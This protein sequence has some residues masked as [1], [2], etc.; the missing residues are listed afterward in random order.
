MRIVVFFMLIQLA[1]CATGPRDWLFHRKHAPTPEE[2]LAKA[3]TLRAAG[4]WEAALAVLRRGVKR[5]PERSELL[6]RL[7]ALDREW[8]AKR[9]LL[10]DR[11]LATQLASMLTRRKLLGQLE[12]AEQ[13]DLINQ[14]RLALL[15]SGLHQSRGALLDCARRQATRDVR[16]ARQ[17][18]RLAAEIQADAES[19]ALLDRLVAESKPRAQKKV[20][21]RGRRKS[22]A[23]A[24]MG[25]AKEKS[26][27]KK[28]LTRVLDQAE[29]LLNTGALISALEQL[30]RAEQLDADDV[31]FQTLRNRARLEARHQVMELT[32]LGDR[33]Y[34]EEHL[35]PALAIWR[36]AQRLALDDAMLKEKIERAERIAAKLERIRAKQRPVPA[37][38]GA[39]TPPAETPALPAKPA[40]V[41]PAS[42]AAQTLEPTPEEMTVP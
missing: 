10:E 31:R 19:A 23:A 15:D 14:S 27:R 20:T 24:A 2:T 40:G 29:A 35:Q 33:L 8:Q 34:R 12:Q 21:T 1:G 25:R 28:A 7:R 42:S 22:G 5:Y 30:Q 17:C 3:K 36:I 26:A 9:L 38:A 32:A 41:P 13:Y 39:A 4:R 11:L 16:L 37:D 6:L 18:A